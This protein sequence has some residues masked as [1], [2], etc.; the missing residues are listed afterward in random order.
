MS[1]LLAEVQRAEEE[2]MGGIREN[3]HRLE[4]EMLRRLR[5]IEREREP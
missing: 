3:L 4:E 2:T 1:K 5:E